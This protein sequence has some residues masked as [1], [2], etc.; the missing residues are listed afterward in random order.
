[1]ASVNFTTKPL[2][3]LYYFLNLD[4]YMIL[5]SFFIVFAASFRRPNLA[6]CPLSGS[7]FHHDLHSHPDTREAT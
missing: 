2:V 7:A 6:S 5:R 4:L 1:M 3:L